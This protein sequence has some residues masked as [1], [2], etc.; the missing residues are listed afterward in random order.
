MR[1]RSW[2]VIIAAA[3]FLVAVAS[4]FLSNGIAE[5]QKAVYAL[6]ALPLYVGAYC[7]MK[8]DAR[9]RAIQPPPGAIPFIALLPAFAIPYYLVATRQRWRRL[10]SVVLLAIY[11]LLVATC[12]TLGDWI[13]RKLAT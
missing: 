9:E 7:W 10:V 12:V 4:G 6:F 1:A 5:N 8:A 3:Y 11:V 13:G 2:S